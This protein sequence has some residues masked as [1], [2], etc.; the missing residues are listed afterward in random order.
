[1]ITEHERLCEQIELLRTEPNK[2]A[3][4]Y[5]LTDPIMISISQQLD[6]LL[7]RLYDLKHPF[8]PN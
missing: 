4:D 8:A 5:K 3:K 2:L 6:A 1:M 7:N